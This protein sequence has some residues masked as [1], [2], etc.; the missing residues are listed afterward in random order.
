MLKILTYTAYKTNYISQIE[1]YPKVN[2]LS[3]TDD[4]GLI[5]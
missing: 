4:R 3:N 2:N 5:T 1:S